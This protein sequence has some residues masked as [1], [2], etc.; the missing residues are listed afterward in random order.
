M[1]RFLLGLVAILLVQTLAVLPKAVAAPTGR[2]QG[3]SG[4]AGVQYFGARYYAPSLGVFTS[5]D[6]GPV[7]PED[8]QSWCRYCGMRGNPVR[9]VD[10]DGRF[11]WIPAV[12]VGG[13]AFEAAKVYAASVVVSSVVLWQFH[14]QVRG[15]SLAIRMAMDAGDWET[16][17]RLLGRQETLVHV[18]GA[19]VMAMGWLNPIYLSSYLDDVEGNE[20]LL[21]SMRRR[22]AYRKAFS[23]SLSE[24]VHRDQVREAAQGR[25]K[26]DARKNANELSAA[27]LGVAFGLD[28]GAAADLAEIR[29]RT[30]PW[31]RPEELRSELLRHGVPEHRVDSMLEKVRVE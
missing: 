24:L 1:R 14:E 18:H 2:F 19:A 3:R 25:G 20:R 27:G 31:A 8:P 22:L 23:P 5:P 17:E 10:P 11:W 15:H 12:I 13:V 29:D 26:T 28:A 4:V 30:G 16:A 6:L 21:F 7:R 9:H